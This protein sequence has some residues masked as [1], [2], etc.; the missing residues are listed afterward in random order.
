MIPAPW[1][2]GHARAV[3]HVDMDAFYAS[4]E[5][6]DNPSL[7]GRP[8]IVGGTPEGRGVVAAASYEARRFGVRSAMS[9][10][11]A[12][13]LCPDGVFLRPR[14]DRYAEVSRAIME[15]LRGTT[16][17][18][19]PLS[20]DEAFL[21]V[22]G[23]RRLLGSAPDIAAGIKLR[24]REQ[25]G[26]IAS[27]G[28]AANKFL[29]KLASDHGKPDGLVVIEPAQGP[30]FIAPLPI[31]RLWGVGRVSSQQLR[32][33]G[34]ERIGDLL[35]R[36]GEALVAAFG[37]HVVHLRELAA[38]IDERPVVPSREAKSVGNE[39]TFAE[40]IA[41]AEQLREVCDGLADKV[42]RRLREDDLRARTVVLKARYPDFTTVTRSLSFAEATAGG[43]ELRDAA[44]ELLERRLGRGRRPLRLLGV[45]AA[46]LEPGQP[47]GQGLLFD[48]PTRER[49]RRV[50][51]VL[52][53]V[54]GRF[55]TLLQRGATDRKPGRRRGGAG[56]G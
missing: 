27:V 16:P 2:C 53:S 15:V 13:Q 14:M 9:A 50:D 6:L 52:D 51:Q 30:A 26:L 56:G 19:E 34:I 46:H 36:D 48:E 33:V 49:D 25:T 28:A 55:G 47:G 29:A 39:L 3:L 37:P 40:D 10:A 31:E 5:T 20:I 1:D 41:D 24:V 8:V 54:A 38:G 23:C 7:S 17:L 11:R 21:D 43:V 18:I 45:T 4:V 22:S 42:A 44:R 32:A 35:T 12:R